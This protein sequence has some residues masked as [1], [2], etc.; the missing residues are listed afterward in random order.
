MIAEIASNIYGVIG[1]AFG[2]ITGVVVAYLSSRSNANKK[3]ST[4]IQKLKKDLEELSVKLDSLKTAFT[5]VF[6]E[7]DR[8]NELPE[9]LKDFKK[10][11]DL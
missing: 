6:D 3:E 5:L 4:E 11:F 10:I 7:M 9:Q 8:K 1:I 2:S